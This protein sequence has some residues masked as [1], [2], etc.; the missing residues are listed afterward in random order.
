MRVKRKKTYKGKPVENKANYA[1]QAVYAKEI[2]RLF[3][4][5][6]ETWEQKSKA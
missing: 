2:G 1:A 5:L 4:V 6:A 3:F